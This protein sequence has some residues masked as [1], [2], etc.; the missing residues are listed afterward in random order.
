MARPM[1]ATAGPPPYIEHC[2]IL[3]GAASSSAM[4][5]MRTDPGRASVVELAGRA[6]RGRSILQGL[7]GVFALQPRTNELARRPKSARILHRS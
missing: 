3:P 4:L 2:F 5:E 6:R 1:S 7:P